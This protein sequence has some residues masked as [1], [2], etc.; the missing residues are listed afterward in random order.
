MTEPEVMLWSKL[1]GRGPDRP[2]F[3][4]QYA[5]E[6]DDLRLLLSGQRGWPWRVTAPPIEPTR[7]PPRTRAR[8]MWPRGRGIEVVRIGAGDVTGT[9]AVWRIP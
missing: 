2:I 3:R 8:D 4:R 6:S 9:S 5:Y 1:K 7:S